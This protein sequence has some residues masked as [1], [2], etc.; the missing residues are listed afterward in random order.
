MAKAK[1]KL[2]TLIGRVIDKMSYG[3]IA[4]YIALILCLNA[5]Y[6]YLLNPLGHGTN[7]SE[8]TWL[9]SLYYCVVT[10]SSLGYGDISPCGFGKLIASLQVLSG[11]ALTAIFVGKI[12]SERQTAMLRLVYTSEHQRR[13]VEFE[14]EIDK[15]NEN[16]ETAINEH[17]HDALRKLSKS[18]YRFIASINNYLK[19]Q[20]NHGDIASF[21]N[22]SAL[23]R[24]YKSLC[25]LQQTIYDI[26][27]TYGVE[28]DTSHKLEQIFSR[29]INIATI[30]SNFHNNDERINSLL[31][32]ISTAKEKLD[33][34]KRNAATGQPEFKY[35]TEISDY[36][37]EKI[38]EKIPPRPWPMHL[39]KTIATE[40]KVQNK[41]VE[42][43][44]AKLISEG[45]V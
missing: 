33:N 29:I 35:R 43:C 5:T 17:N 12:A 9:D 27:R 40:L 26:I 21:G 37:L 19:F 18:V 22:S 14:K 41:L 16:L 24:L 11:L 31:A 10:F 30:M 1:S 28:L 39:H 25:L 34:W 42:R 38:F 23:R 13:L 45:R 36:L 44:I 6:F 2:T 7:I 4:F 8:L 15:L 32:E 20:A 3:K